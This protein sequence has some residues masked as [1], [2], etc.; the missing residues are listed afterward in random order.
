M[1]TRIGCE[2][3]DT[4]FLHS[5]PFRSRRRRRCLLASGVCSDVLVM[6][7][8]MFMVSNER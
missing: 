8:M 3:A 2:R 1:D 4:A 7:M 5:L 6:M